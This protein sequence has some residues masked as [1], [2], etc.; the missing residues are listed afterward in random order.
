MYRHPSFVGI[1]AKNRSNFILHGPVGRNF[2]AAAPE[3]AQT[4]DN[5]TV[6]GK[7]RLPEIVFGTSKDRCDLSAQKPVAVYQDLP[8]SED[9]EVIKIFRTHL[10][11]IGEGGA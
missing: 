1:R 8:S 5:R 6:F 7:H 9:H 3:Y 11:F 2:K 10:V 4:V